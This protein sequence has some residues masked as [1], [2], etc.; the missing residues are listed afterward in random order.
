MILFV[1]IWSHD[2]IYY[3][4]VY[5]CILLFL[6]VIVQV[7]I[8]KLI[9]PIPF[10]STSVPIFVNLG[11][12]SDLMCFWVDRVFVCFSLASL[13]IFIIKYFGFLFVFGQINNI[14]DTVIYLFLFDFD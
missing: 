1:H 7:I 2:I 14:D 8:C 3:L 5:T 12:L 4:I 9:S 10:S 6:L 13:M 11:Q